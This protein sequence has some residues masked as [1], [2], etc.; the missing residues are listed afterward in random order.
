MVHDA[1]APPDVGT[2]PLRVS[3]APAHRVPPISVVMPVYNAMPFLP[4]AI[5]SIL[6]QDFPDF[7][8]VIGDDASSDG[9]RDCLAGYARRDARIRVVH[10]RERRG[11]AGSS[12]WV[13]REARAPLVARMDADDV[14]VPT[15][16]GREARAL[17]AHPAAVLV[18]SLYG[19]IDR[20]GH[21][22]FGVDRSGLCGRPAPPIAHASVMY[23]RD[24]FEAA[25]GY[26]AGTEFFEDRDLYLWMHALGDILVFSEALVWYRHSDAHARL[27]GDRPTLERVLEV[28]AAAAGG[29]LAARPHAHRLSPRVFRNIGALRVWAGH[30][31]GV[32]GAMLTRMRLR[33]V[34]ESA[35]AL[36]W[37]AC[38]TLSPAAVRTA[39]RAA[40]AWRDGRAGRTIAANG[41]YRWEPGQ[42]AVP[43]DAGD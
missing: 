8:F 23:R 41:L 24:A 15:R 35:P 18:G 5:E 12:D 36:A 1:P 31:P 20:H 13:A 25:G 42:A 16:L 2:T 19:A 10:G 34:R 26:R 17:A 7:E 28:S 37:A 33:P 6:A 43:V 3:P 11:S 14:A 39:S 21:R 40:R 38:A 22:L 32:V 27:H 30:R 9:S 29:A 4:Q